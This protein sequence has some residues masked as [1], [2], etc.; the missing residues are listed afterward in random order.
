MKLGQKVSFTRHWVKN[1]SEWQQM[2]DCDNLHYDYKKLVPADILPKVGILVGKRNYAT[3]SHL[4]WDENGRVNEIGERW[5]W[6]QTTVEPFYLVACD[7]TRFYKV[8][9]SDLQEVL[10]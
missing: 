6:Y 8:K 2:R 1:E 5:V 9:E 10:I 4:F 3:I 7:L